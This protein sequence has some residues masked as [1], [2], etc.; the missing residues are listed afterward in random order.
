MIQTDKRPKWHSRV[1]NEDKDDGKED[2][3]AVNEARKVPRAKESQP[4]DLSKATKRFPHH[5]S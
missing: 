2:T 3:N 1:E 4:L 5:V